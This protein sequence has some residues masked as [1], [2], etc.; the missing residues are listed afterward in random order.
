MCSDR[1]SRAERQKSEAENGLSSRRTQRSRYRSTSGRL[2]GPQAAPG[3][4][5]AFRVTLRPL[6][7]VDLDGAV[8]A[9]LRGAGSEA[10]G[11]T[12]NCFGRQA[13]P[14]DPSGTGQAFGQAALRRVGGDSHRAGGARPPPCRRSAVRWAPR[15][16][17]G[18]IARVRTSN[19]DAHHRATTAGTRTPARVPA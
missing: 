17:P 15:P 4:L 14:P 12:A 19:S 13:S 5:F 6:E 16:A 18:R 3:G 8:A 7:M 11:R 10:T 9:E 1:A 2:I